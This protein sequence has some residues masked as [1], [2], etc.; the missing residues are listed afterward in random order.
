MHNEYQPL[1]GGRFYAMLMALL[2]PMWEDGSRFDELINVWETDLTNYERQS[3]ESIT[4]RFKIAVITKHAP[5][6]CRSLVTGASSQSGGDYQRLKSHHGLFW[7]A[8]WASLRQVSET[9]AALFRSA[10]V[11]SDQKCLNCGKTGREKAH[12]RA[13][14]GGGKGKHDK[15]GGKGKKGGKGVKKD[16]K[17]GGKDITCFYRQKTGHTK[18]ECRKRMADEKKMTTGMVTS[19]EEQG[20]GRIEATYGSEPDLAWVMCIITTVGAVCRHQPGDD[21]E[22]ISIDSG[23]DVHTCPRRVGAYGVL[24]R[25]DHQS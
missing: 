3:G 8:A 1:V 25:I 13:E 5:S 16:G 21:D 14:G 20:V 18:S 15:G 22:W 4:A 17:P 24:S 7:S 6:E 12:C 2:S 19:A 9:P 23:S 10:Y 11:G